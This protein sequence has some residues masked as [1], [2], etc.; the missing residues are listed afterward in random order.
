MADF[1]KFSLFGFT[2]SRAKTEEEGSKAPCGYEQ[3][4]SQEGM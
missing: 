1:N 3:G 4:R 2:I